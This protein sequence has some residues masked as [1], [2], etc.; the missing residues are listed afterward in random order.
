[1]EADLPDGAG[2]AEG[3]DQARR[4]TPPLAQDEVHEVVAEQREAGAEWHG[5]HQRDPVRLHEYL[6]E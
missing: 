5:P 1:M 2:Q 3:R 6:G 4:G